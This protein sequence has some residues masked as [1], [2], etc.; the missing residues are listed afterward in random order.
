[1]YIGGNPLFDM[2]SGGRA[3]VLKVY[4]VR[5]AGKKDLPRVEKETRRMREPVDVLKMIV[6]AGTI[7]PKVLV[8]CKAPG[9]R[10]KHAGNSK[11]RKP[12]LIEHIPPAP[13]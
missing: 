13:G 3:G 8:R 6:I 2:E 7:N 10:K 12:E 4:I 1:M 5:I 11:G 9:M